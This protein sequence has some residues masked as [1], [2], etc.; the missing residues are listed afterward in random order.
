ML[1][2]TEGR[3]SHIKSIDIPSL[4]RIRTDQILC[5]GQL[6]GYS[7]DLQLTFGKYEVNKTY[8]VSGVRPD[9]SANDELL[10][11]YQRLMDLM[12]GVE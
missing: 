6:Q 4:G 11:L 2:I 10:V 9:M 8:F 3:K 1:E 7:F 12:G 5:V